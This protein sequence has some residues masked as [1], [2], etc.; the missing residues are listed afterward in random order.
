MSLIG[1]IEDYPNNS[2]QGINTD[3]GAVVLV[4][5]H[6][7]LFLYQNECPHTRETLDPSGGSVATNGGLLIQCQRHAAEFI[8]E[9]G[10]CVSGP[11]QG[12]HL[13][14]IAFTLSNGDI[15]LD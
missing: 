7:H 4:K 3:Y 11:C 5:R 10:E 2:A 12:E 15:Y 9:T 6:G 1:N 8:A 13:K 14:T